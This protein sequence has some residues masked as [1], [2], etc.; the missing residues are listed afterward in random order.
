MNKE[1]NKTRIVKR[2]QKKRKKRKI[3]MFIMLPLL[4]VIVGIGLYANHL[5]N[6]AEQAV[7]EAFEEDGREDGSDLRAEQVDPDIDN[8]SILFIGI[9]ESEKRQARNESNQL[10]DALILATLNKDSNSVK[11]LSIPRD[12]Y[13][14]VPERD[15]YTKINHAHSYGGPEA[16][17]ETVENFLDIPVD[18]YVRLN[19]NAFIDVVDTLNGIE[20]EVPYEI[21]E[22][23]SQDRKNAIHLEQGMQT[24]N[25]EEALA[26]ARTRKM[27]NDIERGKRQQEIIKAIVKK[28]LSLGSVLKYD[29]LIEAV[30]SNMKTSMRFPEMKSLIS[31]G[32]NG[33]ISIET[34]TLSGQDMYIDNIYYYDVSEE[35]LASVQHSL[36]NHLDMG[37]GDPGDETMKTQPAGTQMDVA[38]PASE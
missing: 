16:T 24:L 9:D 33:D 15:R 17:I 18:Y 30:G 19:F 26:L 22:Q 37:V 35:S 27:D 1:T 28:S 34:H 2:K 32:L 31:Y 6:E 5:I 23:D 25:G 38:N 13:V 29:N 14:Y 36:K 7:N 8:I 3:L 4:L 12:T 11:L 20:V 10:S 21:H